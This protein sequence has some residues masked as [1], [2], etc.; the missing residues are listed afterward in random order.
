MEVWD[1]S[2]KQWQSYGPQPIQAPGRLTWPVPAPFDTWDSG[3]ESRYRFRYNDGRAERL[4][5]EMPGP[6]TIPTS[7][8][9][10]H[11]GRQIGLAALLLAVP[12]LGWLLYRRQRVY[13]HS[14]VG[15]AERLLHQV[16]AEPGRTLVSLHQASRVEPAVLTHLSGLAGNAGE[17]ALAGL[18]E[19]FH[20]ILTRPDLAEEGLRLVTAGL[21]QLP[22]QTDP[23]SDQL[24]R[25]Y[26]VCRQALAANTVARIIMMGQAELAALRQALPPPN[27]VLGEVSPVVAQ[28]EQVVQ[29]LYRSQLVEAVED[30]VAYLAQ[31]LE[32]LGRL[33]REVQARLPQPERPLFSQLISGW[34]SVTSNA[35]Q[36]LQG[37]AQLELSL[38]TP[39]L[40]PV[41][42]A[43]V[44]LQLTNTGR[45]PAANV[46][47]RL[48]PGP[49]YEVTNGTV[50][51]AN[52]PAGGSTQVEIPLLTLAATAP[53]RAEFSVTYDDPERR[54]K[55][56]AFADL[57]QVVQPVTEFK[58]I[59]NPYV[60]GTPL[61][62][63][64]PLFFGR[65]D[66]FR[67]VAEN[68]AGLT[69]QNILVLIGQRRMGKTSFLR[70]LST[71]LSRDCL[72]VYLDGQS[73]GI[74]PG[75]ANFFYDLALDISDTLT[76]QGI[77]LA[78][79][80]LTDF[81]ARPS[82]VFERVFLPAV[83]A[84][85][86]PRRLLL[87]LDEFEELE[88]RVQAGK[89]T[90]D[91]FS[92]FRHLMQHTPQVGFIFVGT[93]RL[94]ALSADYWSIFF[95]IA[96]YRHV[97]FLD[98]A[99]AR[100]LVVEPVAPY[101][102]RYDELALDKILRVTA[103]HPYFL[104]LLCHTLVNRANRR[105][106]GYLTI[107]DVNDVLGELVELGEA[108][109]A[110]LWEQSSQPERLILAT[111][112]HLLGREPTVTAIQLV[113]V[114]AERGMVVTLAQVLA[115]LRRLIERD[116]VREI[117]GEPS[118]YEYK[119]VLVRLWIERY[120]TLGR[121]IEENL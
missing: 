21:E 35:L 79:P 20:L 2:A 33:D 82:R 14:P 86:Y 52:L 46:A 103:G 7:P 102:L 66:L 98:E 78:R 90:P 121:V 54:N 48:L 40:P 106:R 38:R 108:H 73:L 53:F 89:L 11:Y 17:P 107:Q 30:K 69:R 64:S 27:P 4:T 75:M 97:A 109:F 51:L 92:F 6:L 119:V 95:N 74:D 62:T 93:H 76:R 84:A 112:T 47:V 77:D 94:E 9:Y 39:S 36:E 50:Q 104:Q 19:G 18:S 43:V 67:F 29:A 110:F 16:Q 91:I 65:E 83:F 59:P 71:R 70:Q 41:E 105:R 68:I 8:W 118:R 72:A 3:R 49:G 31:A 12:V 58:P 81:K 25:L 117:S 80:N 96:L 85:I 10:A 99:A 22:R 115:S 45:S 111:L 24:S 1:P 42:P 57:V 37:R 63:G 60:P 113:Q 116:I 28:L 13:Q 114:L 15:R 44:A 55:S 88:M 120:K 32:R 23:L 56:V 100:T 87:L 26:L 34:L 61:Q 5:A 101:G